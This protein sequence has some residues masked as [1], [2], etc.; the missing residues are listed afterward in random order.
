M[1]LIHINGREEGGKISV[2]HGRR[3][4]RGRRDDSLKVYI[5]IALSL[6][7]ESWE[8]S[9]SGH[10]LSLRGTSDGG[11]RSLQGPTVTQ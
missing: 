5:S 2:V 4:G 8:F 3:V 10:F 11:L 7:L 1:T 9:P 6:K